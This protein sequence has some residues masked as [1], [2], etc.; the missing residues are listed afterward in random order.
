MSN[1]EFSGYR[2]LLSSKAESLFSYFKGNTFDFEDDTSRSDGEYITYGITFTLT[3]TYVGRL[4]GDWFV[5]ENANPALSFTLNIKSHGNTNGKDQANGKKVRIEALDAEATKSELI[6]TL[7]V[8]L[9]A[10]FLR[11]SVF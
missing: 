9:A 10:A 6:A 7:S 11:S 4:L 2:K 3:H 8:A 1:Y 5:G